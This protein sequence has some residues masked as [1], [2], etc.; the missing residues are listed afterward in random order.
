MR[1]IRFRGILLFFSCILLF[2]RNA[3][4]EEKTFYFGVGAFSHYFQKV[5]VNEDGSRGLLGDISPLVNANIE[6]GIWDAFRFRPGLAWTFIPKRP[7]NSAKSSHFIFSIP[8]IFEFSGLELKAGL[9]LLLNRI[10]GEGGNVVLNNGSSMATFSR[11]SGSSTASNFFASLG[12]GVHLADSVRFDFDLILPGLLSTRRSL[13]V[14][15]ALN[16]GVL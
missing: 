4:S 10:S 7:D 14:V 1:R 15:A 5:A 11:P 12:V 2:G 6:F 8:A 13:G 9:G 3:Q 16:I